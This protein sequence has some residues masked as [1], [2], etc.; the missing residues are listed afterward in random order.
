MSNVW[1][2][3]PSSRP[4]LT[5]TSTANPTK[6]GAQ[7]YQLRVFTSSASNIGIADSSSTSVAVSVPLGATLVGEYLTI[8]PGQWYLPGAGMSV[9]EM[10]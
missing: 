2:K 9:T 5:T 6:S 7:T 4:T 1:L 8:S 3:Q 10:S